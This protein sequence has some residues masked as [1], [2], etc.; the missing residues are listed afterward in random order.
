MDRYEEAWTNPFGTTVARTSRLRPRQ[1]SRNRHLLAA[2]DEQRQPSGY[3]NGAR[4]CVGVTVTPPSTSSFH[5]ENFQQFI[6]TML[7]SGTGNQ[8]GPHGTFSWAKFT[9]R[10]PDGCIFHFHNRRLLQQT[11][12]LSTWN[13]CSARTW[14]VCNSSLVRSCQM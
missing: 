6:V 8:H 4:Y 14:S 7:V 2:R 10:A 12:K 9:T 5:A 13:S 3:C 1:N 11:A